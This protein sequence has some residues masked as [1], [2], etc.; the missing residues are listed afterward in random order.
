MYRRE[1]NDRSLLLVWVH[2]RPRLIVFVRWKS[3]PKSVAL[4]PF[5]LYSSKAIKQV[6]FNLKVL[7]KRNILGYQLV[8]IMTFVHITYIALKLAKETGQEFWWWNIAITTAELLNDGGA[9]VCGW[10]WV[11][12]TPK[13]VLACQSLYSFFIDILSLF[14][15]VCK[16]N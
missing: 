7:Y 16:L 11:S 6:N 15:F 2:K 5:S 4:F 12:A 3:V 10:Q 1:K 14:M 8:F 13:N 9:D